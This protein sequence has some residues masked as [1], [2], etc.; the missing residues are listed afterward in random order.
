MVGVTKNI[1]E[2]HLDKQ[3][4]LLDSPGVIFQ[5]NQGI[6]QGVVRIEKLNDVVEAVSQI[7]EKV[8][9]IILETVYKI[10]GFENSHSFL[11]RLATKMGKL[12]K[13]GVPDTEAAAKIVIQVIVF[14]SVSKSLGLGL[15]QR[16]NTFP[17]NTTRTTNC[18]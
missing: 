16:Q 9:S 2:V 5:K 7:Y 11:Q 6:L 18:E 15:E 1:Q 17:H 10:N 4:R 13:G 14:R 12:K 3:I 8:Q